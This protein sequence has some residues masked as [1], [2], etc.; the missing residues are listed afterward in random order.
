MIERLGTYFS[1]ILTET[2]FQS[3]II[4]L[5]SSPETRAPSQY[6]KRRLSVKYRKVSKPRD[7]YLELS[8]RSEI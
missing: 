5:P 4:G 1:E 6:P 8:D 2:Y 3:D 7:L